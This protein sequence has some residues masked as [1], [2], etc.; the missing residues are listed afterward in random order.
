[1]P[2]E[3]EEILD[4]LPPQVTLNVPEHVLVRWFPSASGT[5]DEATL[6]RARRYALSC[7]CKFAYHERIREG[8]FYKPFTP[9]E[10]TEPVDARG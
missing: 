7:G 10:R 1:M 4:R 5:V 2:T 3:I 6:V 9:T 8:I